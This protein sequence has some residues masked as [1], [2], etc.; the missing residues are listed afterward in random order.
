MIPVHRR[1]GSP[2]PA[3]SS[4]VVARLD[5]LEPGLSTLVASMPLDDADRVDA[6]ALDQAGE[7]AL[8]LVPEGEAGLFERAGRALLAWQHGAPLLERLFPEVSCDAGRPPRLIVVGRR[9][10][11]RTVDLLRL[12][13]ARGLLVVE[14]VV[15][16]GPDGAHWL[17]TATTAAGE[18]PAPA[19][20][21]D[22]APATPEL[23]VPAPRALSGVADGDRA[24]D[25]AVSDRFERLKRALLKL[26][27][28]VIEEA[29]G[30]LVCF[31]VG[32]HLLAS[33]SR[34]DGEVHVRA[35]GG[36]ASEIEVDGDAGLEHAMDAVFARYFDLASTRRRIAEAAGRARR[37]RDVPL[38]PA[39]ESNHGEGRGRAPRNGRTRGKDHGGR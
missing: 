20:A 17:V 3:L 10:S 25:D 19:P 21:L 1:N 34:R 22:G 31:R 35:G 5:R 38:Q 8:V 13:P 39:E 24:P 7:P 16:D 33:V 32:D 14:C 4:L 28:D 29:D 9:F 30:D 37:H 27:P 6:V 18:G 15:L 23:D 12:L 26:S 11:E 2:E 36:D